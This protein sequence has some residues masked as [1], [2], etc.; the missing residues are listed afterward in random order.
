MI[1]VKD[2]PYNTKYKHLLTGDFVSDIDFL[3]LIVFDTGSV[4]QIGIWAKKRIEYELQQVNNI[5][6]F[7]A[8]TFCQEE[9]K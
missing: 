8:L 7:G 5:L 6:A 4:N 3:S 2:I 9:K 1:R